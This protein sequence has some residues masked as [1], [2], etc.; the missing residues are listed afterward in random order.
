[1]NNNK[2]KYKGVLFDL[3]GTILYTLADICA[4]INSPLIKRGVR[5]LSV[6]ETRVIVGSGLLNALHKAFTIRAYKLSE[7]ELDIAYFELMEYYKNNATKYCT[8]Y[9]GIIDLLENLDIPYGILSNKADILV[10]DIARVIFPSLSFSYVGG[11]VSKETKKPNPTNIIKF[12]TQLNIPI[13]DLLYV[14]DSEVDYKS[15]V[16]AQCGLVLVSWGYRDK[17]ELLKLNSTIVDTVEELKGV[18][19]ANK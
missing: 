11:M 7:G 14:G 18:I 5:E 19:D 12:A 17:E 13:N 6:S 3:D 1:M 15:A 8:P 9:N 10:K 2:R 4:A 16:N